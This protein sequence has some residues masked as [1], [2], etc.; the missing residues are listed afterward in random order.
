MSEWQPIETV[1]K[2]YG[3]PIL[4]VVGFEHKRTA[5]GQLCTDGHRD[6]WWV[7]GPMGAERVSENFIGLPTHWMPLPEPP[8]DAYEEALDLAVYLR[9][10][11]FERDGK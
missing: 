10:A 9:Q 2:D 3:E 4:L 8:K 1:P 11:L 6:Y 5:M 7:F